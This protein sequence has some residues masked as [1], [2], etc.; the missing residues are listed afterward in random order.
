MEYT[1]CVGIKSTQ[2]PHNHDS[3][4]QNTICFAFCNVI[5]DLCG[6]WVNTTVTQTRYSNS[7][8]HFLVFYNGIYN[9]CGCWVGLKRHTNKTLHCKT[10][11]FYG[12]FVW[13]LSQ[14]KQPHKHDIPLQTT[15]FLSVLQW[16]IRFVWVLTRIGSTQLPHKHDIL[17]QNTVFL[18]WVL[19]RTQQ[20]YK[21]PF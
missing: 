15:I 5:Y 16:N 13:V 17:S 19:S 9:L 7:K 4:S 21:K 14:T 18:A 2:Q 12:R 3:P 11:F 6:Y 20:P 10:P 1:I 8:H